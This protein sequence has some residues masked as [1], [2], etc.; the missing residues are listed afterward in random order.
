[1]LIVDD[2]EWS[3]RSL[4]TVLMP[5][6]FAVLRAFTGEKGLA[7][8]R[9]HSPDIVVV[10]RTLP[11]TDGLMLCR[12]LRDQ[13]ILGDRVP[14]LVILPERPTRAERL[15]ALRAGAWDVLVPPIDGEELVLRLRAYV[16][17]KFDADRLREAGLLDTG[18]GL[19]NV[20]G[21]ERR[22]T[23]L[24]SWAQRHG[25]SLSCVI[26]GCVRAGGANED[27]VVG[28]VE[29]MADM[30]RKTGRTSDAIGRMGQTEFAV[31]APGT[32]GAHA[33]KLAERLAAALRKAGLDTGDRG[34]R[35]VRLRAG[36]DAVA[37]ASATPVKG[38]ELI[39]RASV[40]FGNAKAGEDGEWLQPFQPPSPSPRRR[41]P[42]R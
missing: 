13:L 31:L 40:A 37:D 30:L 35:G 6:G 39:T 17:A 10:A 28:A 18:T 29:A 21:L 12:A 23:E 26:L 36:Y 38:P 27:A 20:T 11:D 42:L 3:A 15:V 4:E 16:Q 24:G 9:T 14:M 25:E 7:R 41:R 32:D 22:A 34:E 1:M 2:Q 5:N 8:A 33:V 19:Y